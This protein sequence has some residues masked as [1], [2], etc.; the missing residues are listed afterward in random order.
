MTGQLWAGVLFQVFKLLVCVGDLHIHLVHFVQQRA[1]GVVLII[2]FRLKT[3][4]EALQ[5]TQTVAHV[6]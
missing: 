2:D 1:N 4:S 3:E 6:F 5:S